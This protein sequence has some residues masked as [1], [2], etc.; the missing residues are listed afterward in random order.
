MSP[1]SSGANVDD[2][3][4]E[5]SSQ[6]RDP[7]AIGEDTRMRIKGFLEGFIEN[8]VTTYKGREIQP[9]GTPL[10]YLS[11]K[12]PK[13]ELKPFHAAII[14]PEFLRINQFERGFSTRL[15]NSFEECAKLIAL[16]H[17]ENAE[18]GYVMAREVSRAALHEIEQQVSIFESAT[19][20]K[21]DRP[22]FSEMVGA[23][24]DARRDDDLVPLKVTTDLYIKARDGTRYF[25]E[26]KSPQPNKGQ[27]LE[28]TQRLLR[29]HLTAGEPRP[30][31][32]AY[33]AMAYNP[34][35][36]KRSN[37]NWNFALNYT[38]FN[39]SVII[40]QEFWDIIGGNNTMENLLSIYQEVGR[41]KTKY[42]LDSLAF[43][44]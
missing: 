6:K 20:R 36:S 25:F 19:K 1:F 24:L 15:G 43:G 21:E 4:N 28:V 3:N 18:R 8:V 44:F 37:Y 27:C 17:H 9:Y 40:A 13:G 10:S 29:F 11:Q 42:M 14:P 41:E 39:E 32:Q 30:N 38:P 22:T 5:K 12:S 26:I 33:F 2:K 34:Y 16:Q 35:G 7:S 23:V 31:V